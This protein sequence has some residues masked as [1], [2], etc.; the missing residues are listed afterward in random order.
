MKNSLLSD[1]LWHAICFT[2]S[3]VDGNLTVY[4]DNVM[5]D[6]TS[7]VRT[8]QSIT[9]GGKW[10]LGQDQDT[11]GGGFEIEDSFHGELVEVNVWGRVLSRQEIARFSTDCQRRMDGDVKRW[12]EFRNGLRGS[13]RAVEEP[14]CGFCQV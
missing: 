8:G 1:G 10:V 13:V 11:V 12:P 5:T 4:K 2:W 6:Q 3:N 9:G 14:G 7:G